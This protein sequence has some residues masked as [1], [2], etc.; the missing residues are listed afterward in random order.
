MTAATPAVHV[1]HLAADRFEIGVRGHVL[2]VDQP[3]D[4]GGED[5]APTPTELFIASRASC[6][7]F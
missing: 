2:T 7:A 6:V 4:A 3:V 1:D 5:T